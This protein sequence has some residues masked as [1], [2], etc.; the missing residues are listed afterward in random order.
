MAEFKRGDEVRARGS[1]RRGVV[2]SDSAFE[3]HVLV[4]FEDDK[5]EWHILADNLEPLPWCPKPGDRVRVRADASNWDP[6]WRLEL[7]TL[8]E[9]KV[10]GWRWAVEM[11]R[12][13]VAYNDE[14]ADF[15]PAPA[16]TH[17]ATGGVVGEIVEVPYAP[18]V[19]FGASESLENTAG[20]VGL[21]IE[22]PAI[23]AAKRCRSEMEKI[24]ADIK[25]AFDVTL[26]SATSPITF[27]PAGV[28][29]DGIH[30]TAKG[31]DEVMRPIADPYAEHRW[32]EEHNAVFASWSQKQDAK[33]AAMLAQAKAQLDSPA[34]YGRM[35]TLDR[36]GSPLKAKGWETEEE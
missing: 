11:D 35:G 30:L 5:R 15:E 24:Q 34:R 21:T 2:I 27:S 32:L 33:H 3:G 6:C 18:A 14:L 28:S 1:K 13:Y 20:T 31:A 16:A 7:G 8:R 19:M 4:R 23:E 36:Y 29:A 26:L 12:G 10:G 22:A 17:D 25:R 9:T